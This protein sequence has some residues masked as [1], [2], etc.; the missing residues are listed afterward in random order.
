MHF[1]QSLAIA[2]L[3]VTVCNGSPILQ[4]LFGGGG[5]KK[6][7][8]PKVVVLGK[9]LTLAK[10]KPAKVKVG[11]PMPGAPIR[12]VNIQERIPMVRKVTI[13]QEVPV[14]KT[15]LVKKLITVNEPRTVVKDYVTY[16][17]YLSIFCH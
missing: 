6:D 13:T 10:L 15:V 14:Q 12:T 3:C 8:G 2:L 4:Q 1:L 16:G 7:E 5:G 17:N 11:E 9:A